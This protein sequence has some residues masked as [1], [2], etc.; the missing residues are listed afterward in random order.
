MH[1]PPSP[2]GRRSGSR[3]YCQHCGIEIP[4]WFE[5]D[6]DLLPDGPELDAALAIWMVTPCPACGRTPQEAQLKGRAPREH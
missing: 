3:C 2:D 1:F 6:G 4:C 5:R